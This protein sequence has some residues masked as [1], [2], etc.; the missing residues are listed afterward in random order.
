MWIYKQIKNIEAPLVWIKRISQPL[1]VSRM[2]CST[3]LK[4]IDTSEV[5]CIVKNIPDKI[6]IIKQTPSREPKFHHLPML[7]GAGRSIKESLII[8]IKGFFLRKFNIG[9]RR[10]T[11]G[12][13]GRDWDC[14]YDNYN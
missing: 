9:S 10:W 4:A 12:R 11:D 5:K 1:L 8:W 2:I 6:W 14:C 7:D 3:L 13:F